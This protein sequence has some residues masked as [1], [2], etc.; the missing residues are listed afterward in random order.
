[1][2]AVVA[3]TRD[4]AARRR[5]FIVLSGAI[6]TLFVAVL[7]LYRPASVA[8]L[9]NAVYDQ[10]L[11]WAGTKPPAER[12][13]VVDV[14]E[15]SL[16]KYGQWPWRRDV[17][18]RLIARLRAGGASV[19]ALDM[20][21]AEPDR[22]DQTS[23]DNLAATLREG[24]VVLGYGLTFDTPSADHQPC[25]LHPFPVAVVERGA[26]SDPFPF[27]RATGA[28]CSLPHLAGAAGSSGF[29]N[30]APDRDGI[31]RRVP[32]MAELD[33][34]MYPSLALA[35]FSAWQG[36]HD[37]IV[38]VSTVN[39][40][41][42]SLA[43][44]RVPLDGKAN[45]LVRFRGSKRT[46]PYL[47]AADVLD[48]RIDPGA[49]RD[50]VVLVG[51][52]ALGTREVVATPLDTLFVGVEVQATVADNLLQADFIHRPQDQGALEA[53]AT[54]AAGT[55]A[56]VLIAARGV[57]L[58]AA[59]A[60]GGLAA[61][62]FAAVWM[63]ASHGVFVSALFPSVGWTASFA[64]VSVA[65]FVLERRRAT[66][67]GVESTAARTLMI[68]A[69]LSLTEVRDAETGRHSR[70]T[71]QYTKVLAQE[72]STHP[73]FRAYL[74]PDRI[75]MLA[76]LAPLHDIGKV[77]VPDSVLNKP[78]ALTPDELAEM[79]RHPVY[80]R[81]VILKAERNALVRD[82][83]I[84]SLAKAIV[85]THH[86]RWDGTG[87]PEGVSGD[88][89]PIPG[90]IV[91]VVDVYDATTT[92]TLYQPSLSHAQALALI[93]SRK[94]THFDPDVIEAFVR[95]APVFE[96]LSAESGSQSVPT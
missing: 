50:K 11:R 33:G 80:G 61:F 57:M 44:R 34:R 96:T 69:M 68:Q 16:S 35:A 48:G 27:F 28:V 6:P 76:G 29:L 52:T 13:I 1:V 39:S 83:E 87:Y 63:L 84:L 71:Q 4:L 32:V 53:V 15:R 3:R 54:L 65:T 18:A 30:A 47:S 88:E 2:T 56:A 46:F 8:R 51:T 73:R 79:R 12:V 59:L 10:T 70:R 20:I 36:A 86:E 74:T 42:L 81:D 90:R 25:V 85:Y 19:V 7:A 66:T 75:D 95:V 62:W 64:A 5:R 21:F 91:A 14:D 26:E 55:I 9:D 45:L 17:I 24:H 40:S 92:R 58:G 72:L 43:G 78:G 22:G 49:L 37:G 93:V 89:I 31:L 67:A 38:E 77:G 41:F 94:G 23:D 82:D 60:A